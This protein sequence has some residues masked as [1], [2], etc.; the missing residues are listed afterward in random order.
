[1]QNSKNVLN[2]N[3]IELLGASLHK[4]EQKLIKKTN[5]DGTQR[6]WYQGEEPYFD[7]FFDLL[8]SE[9]IW[10]Q[11]TLRAKSL[12]WDNKRRELQTGVTNELKVDD[13][14]FYA[15]TKTIEADEKT[16]QNFLELVKAILQTR[17]EEEIF[18]KA[19]LLFDEA[20]SSN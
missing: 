20:T 13:V 12:S 11:F 7:I 5:Q 2:S 3:E 14:S 4:I 18:K 16:D 9:I 15:A 10:F 17:C 8:D 6:I 19:L 1:M